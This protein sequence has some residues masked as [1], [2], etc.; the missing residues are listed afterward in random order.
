MA[1]FAPNPGTNFKVGQTPKIAQAL[2]QLGQKLGVTIV[3]ISGYRT[4]QHSVAV[5]GFADDPHTKGQAA[6]I[7]VNSAL[8]ATAGQL[9]A[10]QLA[11]VGLYRPF[12]GA[13]EIN[14]VQLLAGKNGGTAAKTPSTGPSMVS[15]PATT[16]KT[17][18]PV[19]DQAAFKAAQ[20]RYVAG[21]FL[22]K[23]AG[24]DPYA[25]G[26]AKTGLSTTAG[27]N[28]LFISGAATTTAPNPSDYMKAQ[29]TLQRIAG[30]S[31]PLAVH[32]VAATGQALKGL[33]AVTRTTSELTP[34]LQ[35]LAS[36]HG[37]NSSDVNAWEQVIN[38]ESG[39]NSRILGSPTIQGSD[40]PGLSRAYGIGQFLGSTFTKYLGPVGGTKATAGQQLAAMAQ[41]IKDRYGSPSAALAHEQ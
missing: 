40:A 15:T 3:G 10:Q 5:G 38:R 7:G 33:P 28:P 1:G 25:A 34:A 39:G 21:T 12:P 8:R 31:T 18:T 30:S 13:N 36:Q 6:D 4:P 37:W 22:S 11:S 26:A 32:P 9:T 27:S 17:T 23:S 20:G 2:N 19:L 24:A 16:V 41:Y 29:T 35:T 14:H